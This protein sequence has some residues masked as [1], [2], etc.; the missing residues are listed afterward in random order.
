MTKKSENEFDLNLFEEYE[1]EKADG[2][3]VTRPIEKLW[4]ELEV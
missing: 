4:K 3:L 2:T 1:K